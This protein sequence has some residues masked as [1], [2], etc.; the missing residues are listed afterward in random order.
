MVWF[1]KFSTLPPPPPEF[2]CCE[3]APGPPPPPPPTIKTFPVIALEG[4][5]EYPVCP[6]VLVSTEFSVP[7]LYVPVD[8][9][10]Y[11]C[12]AVAAADTVE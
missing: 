2:Q 9:S 10:E 6:D 7:Q 5:H 3:S 8:V 1:V 11:T 12:P 4:V